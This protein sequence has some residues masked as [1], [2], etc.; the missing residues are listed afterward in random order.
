MQNQEEQLR[1]LLEQLR[2]HAKSLM[3]PWDHIIGQI[4]F[5]TATNNSIV[6]F[7]SS[8]I[9]AVNEMIRRNSADTAVCFLNLPLPPPASSLDQDQEKY[10]ASLRMLTDE[11]P[12]T[13]LVHGLSSVIST[14]L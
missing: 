8:F 3:I 11:L 7:D 4:N 5:S 6:Q 2:I 13:L 1:N 10:L 14:N 12:P 9:K